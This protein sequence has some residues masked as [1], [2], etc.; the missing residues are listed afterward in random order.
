[1]AINNHVKFILSYH[2]LEED[3][4]NVVYRVV[5]FRAETAS[6]ERSS[7][8]ISSD[9]C[10]VKEGHAPQ[11]I[12]KTS[13]NSLYFTYSIQWVRSDIRSAITSGWT[14]ESCRVIWLKLV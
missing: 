2:M 12:D 11:F 3:P 5:G 9:T 10:K 6:V 7:Y 1:M 13:A 4:N 8:E 14:N